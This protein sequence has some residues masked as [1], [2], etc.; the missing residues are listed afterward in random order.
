MKK[1]LLKVLL[2]VSLLF[3]TVSCSKKDGEDHSKDGKYEIVSIY[4][5]EHELF[6]DVGDAHAEGSYIKLDGSKFDFVMNYSGGTL[7]VGGRFEM[8]EDG[9]TMGLYDKDENLFGVAAY[10]KEDEGIYLLLT[11]MEEIMYY[12]EK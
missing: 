7:N 5:S 6:L 4:S 10:V 3:V 12:F 9:E 1:N 8:N 2:I 11:D